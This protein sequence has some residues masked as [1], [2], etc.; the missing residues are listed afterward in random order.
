VIRQNYTFPYRGVVIIA[1]LW[2]EET[3]IPICLRRDLERT[4]PTTLQSIRDA[5][6]TLGLEVHHY[7]TPKDLAKCANRHSADVVL[8][9]FGGAASRSRMALVPAICEAFGIAYIGPDA[10]GR[11]ICQDKEV[12]KSLAYEAGLRIPSHR[13]VRHEGEIGKISDFPLP[14]VV[15]PLWDGSSI[16]IGPQNLVTMRHNGDIVI[17]HLLNDFSQPVMIEEFIPGRETSWCFIDGTDNNRLRSFVEIVWGDKPDYFDD[18]LYDALLKY[19]DTGKTVRVITEELVEA[20][21]HALEQLL[22][23]AGPIGYGR[24]DGKFK[25]G[26]FYFLEITPDAWLDPI[27]TF[28]CSFTT[29]GFSFEE[30]IA[31]LLLSAQQG[32]QGRSANDS[33][34]PGDI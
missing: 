27:G 20:D 9:I 2:D 18:H 17:R 15:K 33:N 31:R 13:I 7:Q 5:I 30:V 4:D 32:P 23:L 3:S 1:D 11:I 10:Y 21:A 22:R 34:I 12:S 28:A 16:G 8:S 29:L 14:Y 24:I 26:R 19:E 6:H 25:D